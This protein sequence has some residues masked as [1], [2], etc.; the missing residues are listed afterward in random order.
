MKGAPAHW[1]VIPAAGV[2]KRM[3]AA[4]PKQYLNLGPRTVIEHTLYRFVCAPQITGIV[5]VLDPQD[6]FWPSLNIGCDKPLATVAGGKER[7]HSVL[8]A[9]EFLADKA[10]PQDWVLVHDAARPC[11][12]NADLQGLIDTL[13]QD[14]VGGILAVPVRDTIK[15]GDMDR[16]IA[17][18]VDRSGLWHALTPQMFRL[19][20][21]NRALRNSLADDY[22]V[23]DEASAMEHIGLKPR[24]VEGRADNIKITRPEDLALAE[25]YLSRD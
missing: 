14:P 4:C 10:D 23:T 12:S 9:L 5:V 22:L 6:S 21:L 24:L 8:N 2:G 7:C 3:D 18:T 15:R 16:R 19:E 17:E 20:A 1:A 13:G 11:L 25:Y